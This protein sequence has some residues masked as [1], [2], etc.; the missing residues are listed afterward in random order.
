MN[1]YIRSL[2]TDCDNV[3]TIAMMAKCWGVTTRNI[4]VNWRFQVCRVLDS[5]SD[6]DWESTLFG[7]I[8]K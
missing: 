1:T 5:G 2:V 4:F 3:N 8:A 7:C 6:F